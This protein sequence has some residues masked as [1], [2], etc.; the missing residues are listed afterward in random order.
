MSHSFPQRIVPFEGDNLIA[1]QDNDGTIYVAFSRLCENLTLSRESQ[2]RRINRHEVLHEGLVTLSVETSGGIQQVQCLKLSLIPLWL[3]GLHANRVKEADLREKLIRYQREAADVLWQAFRG[4]IVRQDTS[5][6]LTTSTDAEFAQLQQIVEMSRAI[7][8]MAEEQIEQRR[9]VNAA[10]RVVKGIR[11]ELTDVQVRLGVLEDKVNPAAY[12]S[13]AQATEVS[14]KVKALAEFL[15]M[16]EPSKNH[17]QGI[18]TELYRRF[19]VSSYKLL[20]RDQ[21]ES[22]IAFLDAWRVAGE[23]EA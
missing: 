16:H 20:R 14:T 11:V 8:R 1:V 18:Y 2:V 21:F 3:S 12:V 13:D 10:A 19:G 15:T 4:Q 22:V 9:R 17:Y 6:E 7:T 23:G 5:D